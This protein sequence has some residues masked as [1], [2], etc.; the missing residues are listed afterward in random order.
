MTH[1]MG[2][3]A[4]GPATTDWRKPGFIGPL[5]PE[6]QFAKTQIQQIADPCSEFVDQ[7]GLPSATRLRCKIKQN[8][9]WF[10]IGGATLTALAIMVFPKRRRR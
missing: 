8:W 3:L 2:F 6:E 4:D 7:S 9:H 10:L 5:T 1:F